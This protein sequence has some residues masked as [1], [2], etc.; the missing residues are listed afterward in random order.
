MRT[1]ILLSLVACSGDDADTAS[2]AAAG[3]YLSD[4]IDVEVP[5]FDTASVADAGNGASCDE[6]GG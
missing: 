6:V 5:G 4:D 3:P 1:L 2:A